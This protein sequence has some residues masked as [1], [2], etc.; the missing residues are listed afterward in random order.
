MKEKSVETCQ[1][2]DMNLKVRITK[3]YTQCSPFT[4]LLYEDDYT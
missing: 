4:S 2:Y 3:I 1:S